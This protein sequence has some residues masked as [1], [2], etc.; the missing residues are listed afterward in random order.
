MGQLALLNSI[1][2]MITIFS[3]MG[4][5]GSL[6]RLIPEHSAKY[7]YYSAFLTYKK[8]IILVSL[9]SLLIASL[10]FFF[11]EEIAE[12]IFHKNELLWLFVLAAPLIFIR[13]LQSINIALIQA[14]KKIK[15]LA[16][17]QLLQPILFTSLI[18]F[19]SYFYFDKKTPIYT[20]LTVDVVLLLTSIIVVYMTVARKTNTGYFHKV[21]THGLLSLSTPMML[22]GIFTVVLFQTDTIM[23]GIMKTDTDVGIYAVVMK[24][25]GLTS[26]VLLAMNT[27][28]TPKF[29]ELYHSGELDELRLVAQQSSKVIVIVSLLIA[30]LLILFGV[31][32]LSF[33]GSE[34]ES[35]Y[36]AMI[37]IL[38]GQVFSA[39]AGLVGVLLNMTGH[40]KTLQYIVMFSASVNIAMNMVLIK[41]YG[42]TGAA[43]ASMCSMILINCL[44]TYHVYKKL[45]IFVLYLPGK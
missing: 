35:G 14:M 38:L 30:I 41:L 45:N 43:I 19:G 40:H 7:S 4:M 28:A 13:S 42:I 31:P 24:L 9:S 2:G 10:Y 3:V 25:A 26:F 44:S 33:F 12:K 36:I 15:L 18:V 5:N 34:F 39:W 11:S 8:S 17:F 37:F 1:V 16:F 29:S 32:I 20:Q 22:T 23:L 21:S 6:M 27:I